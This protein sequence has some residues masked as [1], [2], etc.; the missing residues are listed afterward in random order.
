V[1][2]NHKT[3][4]EEALD[5]FAVHGVGG[6]WGCNATGILAIESKAGAKGAEQGETDQERIQIHTALGT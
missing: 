5:G 4:Q 2:L 6:I 1:E 3:R